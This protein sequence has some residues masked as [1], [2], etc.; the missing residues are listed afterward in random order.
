MQLLQADLEANGENAG[1]SH[2]CVVNDPQKAQVLPNGWL[3]VLA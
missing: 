3:S 2:C 1:E